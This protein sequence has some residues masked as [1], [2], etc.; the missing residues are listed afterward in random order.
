MYSCALDNLFEG[1]E[2]VRVLITT[3]NGDDTTAR[4][5]VAPILS[6]LLLTA[7]GRRRMTAAFT[8]QGISD[9]FSIAR[10]SLNVTKTRSNGRKAPSPTINAPEWTKSGYERPNNDV[11]SLLQL[12]LNDD[13]LQAVEKMRVEDIMNVYGKFFYHVWKVC[14]KENGWKGNIVYEKLTP[15]WLRGKDLFLYSQNGSLSITF[16]HGFL[17]RKGIL[18]DRG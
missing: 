14:K 3:K 9:A 6:M 2:E 1:C 17:P 16:F 15:Q 12:E 10:R 13:V 4:H 11:R 8:S 7:M 18:K 5:M